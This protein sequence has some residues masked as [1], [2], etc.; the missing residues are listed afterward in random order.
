[1]GVVVLVDGVLALVDAVE[2]LLQLVPAVRDVDLDVVDVLGHSLDAEVVGVAVVGG[3][4]ALVVDDVL[5]VAD[6]FLELRE[7]VWVRRGVLVR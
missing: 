5:V 1:M 6:H 2:L 4:P 3:F 7:R